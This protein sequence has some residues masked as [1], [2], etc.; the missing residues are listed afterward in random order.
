MARPRDDKKLNAIYRASLKLILKAGF[1]GVKM[2]LVAKEAGIGTGTVYIYFKNKEALIRQLYRVIRRR[3]NVVLLT[4]HKPDESFMAG[5]RRVWRNYLRYRLG[6]PEVFAFLEQYYG[7]QFFDPSTTDRRDAWLSPIFELLD[8]GK[9]QG[10]VA[11]IPTELLVAQLTGT[12][13]EI[14]KWHLEGRLQL[15]EKGFE[16][17]YKMAWSSIRR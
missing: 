6:R 9:S 5:F 11:P 2:N 16:Y 13:N 4:G 15:D 14:G 3:S 17:A 1:G 8:K 7:S 12:I 10:L